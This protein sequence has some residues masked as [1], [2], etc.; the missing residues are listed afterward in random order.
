MMQTASSS[1][2]LIFDRRALRR[3]RRRAARRQPACDFLHREVAERLDDRL[4]DVLRD[5]P[6][7]VELGCHHGAL[8][9]KLAANPR[10]GTV[11]G[12][13]IAPDFARA[14]GHLAADE[15]FLPFAENSIDL[16]V[17]NMALHW[18][19]DTPGTLAQIRRCLKPDGLFLAALIGGETLD[20]LRNCFME[21]E[22]DIRGGAGA[23]VSPFIDIRDGGALLQRAGFALPVADLE[24]VTVSYEN[25]FSLMRDLR[26]MGEGNVLAGRQKHFTRRDVMMKAAALYQQRF[27]DTDG[28][29]EARFDILFLIGW[30]PHAS[31][32]KPLAP[33][34]GRISLASAV[35]NMD[36]SDE[37]GR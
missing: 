7:A 25:A 30:K 5:F 21:A 9:E 13:D 19:N 31:Q 20:A 23:H 18:V 1:S 15:E 29:I 27:S 28:R 35:E 12:C 24:P 34:S 22:L 17:S 8:S 33:G 37:S 32:P 26:H 10:I 2:P 14:H 3:Q 16:I 4:G 6:L 36:E 11:F